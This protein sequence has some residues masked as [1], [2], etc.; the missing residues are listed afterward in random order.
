MDLQLFPISITAFKRLLHTSGFIGYWNERRQML[1]CSRWKRS[2]TSEIRKKKAD[3]IP[4]LDGGEQPRKSNSRS[5]RAIWCCHLCV[6]VFHHKCEICYTYP[7]FRSIW[8]LSRGTF[9]L[10][11]PPIHEVFC[12]EPGTQFYFTDSLFISFF[13]FVCFDLLLKT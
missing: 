11:D 3:T 6:C 4:Y 5:H 10:T 7:D 13:G 2:K 9:E 12:C 1:R 8:D